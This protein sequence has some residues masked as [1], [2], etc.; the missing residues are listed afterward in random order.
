MDNPGDTVRETFTI[1]SATSLYLGCAALGGGVLVIQLL[2][3]LVGFGHDGTLDHPADHHDGGGSFS[4]LSVRAAAGFMLFFGLVGFL[5]TV[6][7][8]G[9]T[10]S[11][12]LAMA[13]GMIVAVIMAWVLSLFRRLT[14]SGNV[15]PQDAVG[16]VASVYLRIPP[17]SSGRGKVTLALGG[18]TV[19]LQAVTQGGELK[20]GSSCRVVRLI[21]HETVE[22]GP[23]E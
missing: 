10:L 3:S 2:L 18:R 23:L 5:G 12:I 1:W 9:G 11:A 13:A 4:L 15:D 14:E 8:W 6:S 16:R 21:D 7:G 19:E 20:T 22:V 17:S